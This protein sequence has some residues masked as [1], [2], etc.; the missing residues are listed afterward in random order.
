MRHD[1]HE[2][3]RIWILFRNLDGPRHRLQKT[4]L[5]FGEDCNILPLF[6][7]WR[8]IG[9]Q[10]AGICTPQEKDASLVTHRCATHAPP[11]VLSVAWRN[12][13]RSH[14]AIIASDVIPARAR[15]FCLDWRCVNN[16]KNSFADLKQKAAVAGAAE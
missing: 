7:H 8:L 14:F 15:V 11:L 12:D 9:N 2:S 10:S 1:A 13:D 5:D 3:V 6:H 4:V 16:R